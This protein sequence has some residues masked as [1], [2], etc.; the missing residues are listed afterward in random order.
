MDR[1]DSQAPWISSIVEHVSS[2]SPILDRRRHETARPPS[3]FFEDVSNE[4]LILKIST[5]SQDPWRSHFFEDVS[6]GSL[7]FDV[8]CLKTSPSRSQFFEDVCSETAVLGG[9]FP[10]KNGKRRLSKLACAH[11][12]MFTQRGMRA[13]GE[14]VDGLP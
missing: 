1:L 3:H 4:S 13:H 8:R 6:S 12:R 7:T 2:D 14:A 5:N 10:D 11:T 9:T